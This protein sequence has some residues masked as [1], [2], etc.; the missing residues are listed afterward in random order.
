MSTLAQVANTD[1]AHEFSVA[2]VMVTK[3]LGAPTPSAPPGNHRALGQLLVSHS[4]FSLMT[5]F[6]YGNVYVSLLLSQFV[7]P[8]PSPTACKSPFS[9]SV[10]PLLPCK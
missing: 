9:M 6:T 5:Y 3:S 4:K 7:P 2:D 1:V 8:S 10:C